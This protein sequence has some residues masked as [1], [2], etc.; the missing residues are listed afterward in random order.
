[1]AVV[2]LR[3]IFEYEYDLNGHFLGDLVA[4]FVLGNYWNAFHEKQKTSSLEGLPIEKEFK[5]LE[6]F[7][8]RVRLFSP[9]A[10]AVLFLPDDVL[11]LVL[12]LS[13]VYSGKQRALYI[14]YNSL[15]IRGTKVTITAYEI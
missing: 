2:G 5:A 7:I 3:K 8:R 14:G 15:T 11:G 10:D 13:L 9:L 4:N 6:E 1:M 12:P